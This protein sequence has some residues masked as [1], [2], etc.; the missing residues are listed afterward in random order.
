MF[1]P[2]LIRCF[3]VPYA[4][5]DLRPPYLGYMLLRF[6]KQAAYFCRFSWVHLVAG[7]GLVW[8]LTVH[9]VVSF[10]QHYLYVCV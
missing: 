9:V 5:T 7:A 4:L 1:S 2:G 6:F 3:A 8:S 10:R